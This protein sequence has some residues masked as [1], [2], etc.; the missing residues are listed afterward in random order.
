VKLEHSINALSRVSFT[1]RKVINPVTN[2]PTGQEIDNWE[3]IPHSTAKG[4]EELQNRINK[5]DEALA[6]VG[7]VDKML[8]IFEWVAKQEEKKGLKPPKEEPAPM[9]SIEKAKSK[10]GRPKKVT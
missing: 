10:G 7:G 6:Q 9:L 3:D 8:A 2:E 5:I 4:L 1:T